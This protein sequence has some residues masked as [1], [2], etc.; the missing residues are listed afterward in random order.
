MEFK[1]S[2]RLEGIGLEGAVI[3]AVYKLQDSETTDPF[4]GERRVIENE[5]RQEIELSYRHE[6]PALRLNYAIEI[7]W[8]D[9]DRAW[10]LNRIERDVELTP[11]NSLTVQYRAFEQTVV[12]FQ[13]RN[14]IEFK[15][16]RDRDRYSGSIAD[17]VL[18][19]NEIARRTFEPEFVI[20]LRGQF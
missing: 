1:G 17:G 15:R 18:V 16:R 13:A 7:E 5:P 6:I 8:E 3:D 9:E 11:R 2:F 19:R 10:D 20:G 12:Y 4:T 14:P